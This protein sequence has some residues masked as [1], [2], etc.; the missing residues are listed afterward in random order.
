MSKLYDETK[1]I[2]KKNNIV[3]NKALGQNFL[4]DENVVESIVSAAEIKNDDLVIEIGPGLGTLTQKLL[5]KAQKVIAVELDKKMVEI[6]NNR[7]KN[8]NNFYIINEDILKIDLNKIIKEEK[9][10]NNI[11]KVKI[12]ANLP[13]YITTPIIMYL[14][15]NRIDLESI[16]IMIQKEVAER[17]VATP[18]SKKCGAITYGVHFYAELQSIMTVPKTSFIPAPKVESQVIKLIIRNKYPVDVKN[19]KLLFD[20]IKYSFM[21]RRKTFINSLENSALKISKDKV[22]LILNELKIEE[23]IRGEKLSLQD[24]A[25]ITNKM[26]EI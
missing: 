1:Q 10:Q 23:N 8:Y 2:M 24:F 9:K 4:I 3:A 14:L 13:Y 6:L 15:E 22:K 7:F 17:I 26:E 5:Q 12:V 16:T 20:L 11:K 18:G 25:N 21:L 19:T